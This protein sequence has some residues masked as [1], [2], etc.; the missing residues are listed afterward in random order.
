M[1]GQIPLAQHLSGSL[2][3]QPVTFTLSDRTLPCTEHWDCDV[4]SD[5][6]LLLKGV[7]WA[8]VVT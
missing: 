4:R 3:S 2:D 5:E 7:Q 8:E 6:R 1:M